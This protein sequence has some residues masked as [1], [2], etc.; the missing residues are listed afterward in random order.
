MEEINVNQ[1]DF[2]KKLVEYSKKLNEK[3]LSLTRCLLLALMR[4]N[5]DG[6]PFRELKVI[7]NISDGKLKSNLDF[8]ED[9][10]CVQKI[11]VKLDQKDMHIYMLTKIGK[12]EVKKI[13][14][15]IKIYG[16]MEKILDESN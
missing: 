12:E 11:P 4:F 16:K 15:W 3:T 14:E 10:G 8:L 5:E 6:L 1:E 7:L 2:L 9:I 13:S